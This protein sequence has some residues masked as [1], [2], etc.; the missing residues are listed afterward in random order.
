VSEDLRL[1]L[2]FV[3][4]IQPGV[5]A[6]FGVAAWLAKRNA[7]GD[8]APTWGKPDHPEEV[9]RQWTERQASLN[10]RIIRAWHVALIVCPVIFVAIA[11]VLA[12]A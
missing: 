2:A 7:Y 5:M 4:L 3:A 1:S 10:R 11:V 8:Y 12:T 9:Q 6:G